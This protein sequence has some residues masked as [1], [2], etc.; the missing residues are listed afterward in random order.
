[1][2]ANQ[3]TPLSFSQHVQHI[4]MQEETTLLGALVAACDE[5]HVPYEDVG[6][7]LINGVSVNLITGQL[8]DKLEA[9][10]VDAGLVKS[11]HHA[12]SCVDSLYG[13][14]DDLCGTAK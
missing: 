14:D 7:F 6:C 3:I 12:H 13:V 2:K 1:M 10:C 8:K 4:Q 5:F 9:E 11:S